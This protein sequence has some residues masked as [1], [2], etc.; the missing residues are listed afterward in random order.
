M[1]IRSKAYKGKLE[2]HEKEYYNSIRLPYDLLFDG[3]DK[4]KN[5]ARNDDLV[6]A[7]F[8]ALLKKK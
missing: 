8:H 5:K 3:E 4:K 7:K 1:K 6:I 2:K